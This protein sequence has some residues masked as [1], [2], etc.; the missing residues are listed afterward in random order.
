MTAPLFVS[1]DLGGA[2]VALLAFLV[3][4]LPAGLAWLKERSAR[5]QLDKRLD[6]LVD[7]KETYEKIRREADESLATRLTRRPRS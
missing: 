1:L 3:A 2:L 4:A 7:R 5:R 6:D